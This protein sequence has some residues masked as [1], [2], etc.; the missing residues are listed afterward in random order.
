M[1][2]FQFPVFTNSQSWGVERTS[3]EKVIRAVSTSLKQARPIH[4]ASQNQ[5]SS[6][7]EPECGL[8]QLIVWVI[9]GARIPS[10]LGNAFTEIYHLGSAHLA[11]VGGKRCFKGAENSAKVNEPL[12]FMCLVG[13]GIES[14]SE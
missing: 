8:R 5:E 4:H 13:S 9:D 7:L 11:K 12:A 10:M 14:R 1:N 3:R 6:Y 2:M